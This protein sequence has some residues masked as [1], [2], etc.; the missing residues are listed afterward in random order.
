MKPLRNRAASRRV[1]VAVTLAAALVALAAPVAFATTYVTN[2]GPRSVTHDQIEKDVTQQ[3]YFLKGA[4]GDATVRTLQP[5]I[6]TGS[7]G[8]GTDWDM[9]FVLP[10][11]LQEFDN[12]GT[13][14]VQLGFGRCN[15]TSGTCANVPPDGNEY[16]I[17]TPVDN[18]SGAIDRATWYHSGAALHLN[19]RYRFRIDKLNSTTWEYCIRDITTGET[20]VCHDATFH[21]SEPGANFAWWAAETATHASGIG[22]RAADPDFS[23]DY[24]QY[25][26][27]QSGAQWTVRTGLNGCSL[28][29][30]DPSWYRCTTATTVYS[31]D[32]MNAWTNLH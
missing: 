13:G 6:A 27:T 32:T 10:A 31:G 12:G 20:Y 18:A 25:L 5:C 3:T 15:I 14:L 30:N 22:V 24:M 8:Q 21:W 23:M 4:I 29:D 11:N 28:P 17:W 26:T 1:L 9:P 19:D 7:S 16:P 2:C